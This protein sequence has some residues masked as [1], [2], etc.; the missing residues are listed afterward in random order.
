MR[1]N[2]RCACGWLTS[3]ARRDDGD[4]GVCARCGG[5]LYEQRPA[6]AFTRGRLMSLARQKR[7]V[8]AVY[9]DSE[10]VATFV[11]ECDAKLWAKAR[12]GDGAVVRDRRV[13]YQVPA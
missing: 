9:V 10:L 7:L 4:Y 6:E 13:H 5:A 8:W 2:V 12:Y 1:A 11:D 3:R